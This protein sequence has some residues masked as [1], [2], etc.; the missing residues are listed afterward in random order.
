MTDE[1]VTMG[2]LMEQFE[3]EIEADTRLKPRSKDYRIETLNQL[4]ATWPDLYEKK[5]SEVTETESKEWADRTRNKFSPTRFNGTL[6]TA[7]RLLRRAIDLKI[8]DNDPT[9]KIERASVPVTQEELPDLVDVQRLLVELDREEV[10]TDRRKSFALALHAQKRAAA[11][12]IKF[13]LYTGCRIGATPEVTATCID[14]V[15]NEVVLPRIKYDDRPVRVPI[16]EGARPFF[17]GL[18]QLHVGAGP[19]FTVRNPSKVLAAAC[20]AIG[21]RRLTCH[22]MRDL[23]GTVAYH[24]TGD[25]ALVAS[26]LG[27]KDKGVTLLKR[28]VHRQTEYVRQQARKVTF[29]PTIGTAGVNKNPS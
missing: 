29:A 16:F 11:N 9:A 26:W 3:R 20:R 13:M 6:E 21:I 27:H 2:V 10:Y 19:L 8:R 4:K 24:A 25:V 22:N 14:L 12:V 5:P 7:R 15:E 23:F 17:E 28:Y 18:L 1:T